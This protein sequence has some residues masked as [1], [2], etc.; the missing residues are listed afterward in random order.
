MKSKISRTSLLAV[1][2]LLLGVATYGQ[3]VKVR[4]KVPFDFILDN[5]KYAAGEYV[6]QTAAANTFQLVI[7]NEK[8]NALGLTRSIPCTTD[9][10]LSPAVQTRLVFHRISNTYFLHQLWLE[11]N[12]FGRQF[13][14][15]PMEIRMARNN[16]TSKVI[17]AT[18]ARR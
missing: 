8:G 6:I 1:S 11:G 3:E 18:D 14:T 9:K 17:V 15:G 10:V 12:S 2:A 16:T 13:P 5:T 4:A 7:V